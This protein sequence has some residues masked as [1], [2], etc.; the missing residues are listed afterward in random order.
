MQFYMYA[1]FCKCVAFVM[2]NRVSFKHIGKNAVGLKRDGT[3]D[4][5]ST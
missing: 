4:Q 5:R 1:G 2:L 3:R